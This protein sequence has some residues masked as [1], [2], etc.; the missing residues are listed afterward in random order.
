[1]SSITDKSMYY[2]NRYRTFVLRIARESFPEVVQKLENEKNVT[3]YIIELI[4]KDLY[5]ERG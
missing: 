2:K 3:S 1:M 5:K 4:L